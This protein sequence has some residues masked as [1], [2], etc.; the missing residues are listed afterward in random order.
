MGLNKD[1]VELENYTSKW[2]E[3]YEEEAIKLK[4]ILKDILIDIEHVG[5]TSI[6]NLKSKPIIDIAISVKDLKEVEKYTKNL[7]DDGDSFR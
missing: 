4:E 7:E 6:P 3:M 5:S 1:K 2:K